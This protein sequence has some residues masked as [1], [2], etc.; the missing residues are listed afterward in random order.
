VQAA[1]AFVRAALDQDRLG[2]ITFRGTDRVGDHHRVRFALPDGTPV[3]AVVA[4]T[5]RDVPQGLTCA[6]TGRSASHYDL[7]ALER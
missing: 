3:A 2:A 6:G 4:V 1:E 5:Q 7:V